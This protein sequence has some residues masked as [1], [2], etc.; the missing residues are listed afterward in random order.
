MCCERCSATLHFT[1][2]ITQIRMP[3]V[4]HRG[5]AFETVQLNAGK[6]VATLTEL[7]RCI[8]GDK[9]AGA[10][11]LNMTIDAVFQAVFSCA[12]SLVHGVISL[13]HKKLHMVFAHCLCRLYALLPLAARKYGRI[14]NCG[15]SGRDQCGHHAYAQQ[16]QP[17]R[18]QLILPSPFGCN[19]WDIRRHIYDSLYSGHNPCLRN[20]PW[21]TDPF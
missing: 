12:N 14:C 3:L 18:R 15:R 11:L 19:R 1:R 8:D 2:R 4:R 5:V 16:N 13:M 7:T 9:L 17:T 21:W 20:D 6:L 10:V